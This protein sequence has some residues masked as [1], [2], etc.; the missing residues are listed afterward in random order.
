M[1]WGL[2]PQPPS[3]T[4]PPPPHVEALQQG[5]CLQTWSSRTP[6]ELRCRKP[7]KKKAERFWAQS[8]LSTAKLQG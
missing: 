2:A 5:G 6:F 4:P 7:K 3:T 8:F 1:L